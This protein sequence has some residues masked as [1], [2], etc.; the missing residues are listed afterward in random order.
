MYAYRKNKLSLFL[1]DEG[2]GLEVS[3]YLAYSAL[4]VGRISD[5]E[6]VHRN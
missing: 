4:L 6:L 5:V 1:L 3:G 2:N